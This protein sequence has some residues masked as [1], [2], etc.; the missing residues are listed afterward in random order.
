MRREA[1][2]ERERERVARRRVILLTTIVCD[3][4]FD[5]DADVGKAVIMTAMT[6]TSSSS[7]SPLSS[8]PPSSSSPPDRKP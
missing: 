2:P 3:S 6:I 5:K 1:P 8:S 7:S 4:D